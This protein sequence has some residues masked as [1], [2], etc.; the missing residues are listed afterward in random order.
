M[1]QTKILLALVALAALSQPVQAEVADSQSSIV[2]VADSQTANTEAVEPSPID[3][4]TLCMT[5]ALYYEA[6]GE[7]VRGQEAVAEVILQRTRSNA[8][9]DTICGVVYEPYQFSFVSDGSTLQKL[10]E[11]A[12]KAAYQLA[13]RVV[14]GE[15]VTSMTKRAQFYHEVNVRPYWAESMIRTAQIGNHVFYRQPPRS[16]SS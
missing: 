12:W 7:G 14:S 16:R 8:H 2:E 4:E 13:E 3:P 5:Q 10:D 1:T 9:P 6:R 11:T 15:L